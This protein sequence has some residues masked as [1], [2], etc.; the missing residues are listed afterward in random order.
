MRENEV[1]PRFVSHIL[2]TVERSIL[3]FYTK[4]L[5]LEAIGE[6][7]TPRIFFPRWITFCGG[8]E[9]DLWTVLFVESMHIS[10][11]GICGSF[12]VTTFSECIALWTL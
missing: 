12:L 1:D 2:H 10:E 5:G 6:R 9:I 8:S 11:L 7:K 4:C 3:L